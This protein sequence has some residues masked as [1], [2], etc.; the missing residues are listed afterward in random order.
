MDKSI[1]TCAAN[2]FGDSFKA[3]VSPNNTQFIAGLFNGHEYMISYNPMSRFYVFTKDDKP[4]L[5]G[6]QKETILEKLQ[7]RKNL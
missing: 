3:H 5:I 4:L 2:L 7:L 1:I 6:V